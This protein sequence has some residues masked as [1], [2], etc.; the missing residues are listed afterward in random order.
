MN[1]LSLLP[2]GLYR[3][4]PR[5]PRRPARRAGRWASKLHSSVALIL[6]ATALPV[7]ADVADTV[8]KVKP[9]VVGVGTFQPT[10]RPR[11]NLL[12]TGFAVLDG[13]HVVSCAH[14]FAKPLDTEKKAVHAVFIGRDRQM[15]VRS[16]RLVATDSARDLALLRIDGAPLPTLKLGDSARAREGWQLYFTGYPIGSILGL[17]ASTHRAGLAAIVPIFTP[18]QSADQLNART[19][20]QARDAYEVFE[21]D[22]IA[23]PGNS[24][25][26]V[27]HP[28]TG[29]VL[30]VLNSVYVKGAKEA[31]LSTP[32][33]ISYA[34]PV[35]YVHALLK[36][37]ALDAAEPNASEPN[38]SE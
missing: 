2:P 35:S 36:R 24:G 3:I 8:A 16:A 25:S 10:G 12:G 20:K 29:E 34:I 1:R 19:L 32:S 37:A 21:L 6:L 14:I 27:W 9:A 33:G 26:P 13:R 5:L 23:Y 18:M 15:A 30:G 17:N 31:A 38:A 4:C 11:A 28:E 22:A 7:E